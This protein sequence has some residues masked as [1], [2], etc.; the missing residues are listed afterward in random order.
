M[1]R[2]IRPNPIRNLLALNHAFD[3]M[4]SN[5][6]TAPGEDTAVR[7]WGLA[8]DVVEHEDN[9]VLQASV[10]GVNADD[11]DITLEDNV[12]TVTVEHNVDESIKED[13][14]RL[15]ERRLGRFT[16]SL[17]F[18]VEINA[19]AIEA[20]HENGVLTLNVPKAEE[21]KPKRITVQVK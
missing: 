5:S 2:I 12:I 17:R 13:N 16:R 18:P 20:T 19:E 1:Y 4:F 9:Y 7:T 15:R 10:P 11:V 3:Q 21:V 6:I 8:L 14:Y